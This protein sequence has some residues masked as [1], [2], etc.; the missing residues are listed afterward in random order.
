MVGMGYIDWPDWPDRL[1]K[2]ALGFRLGLSLLESPG[3]GVIGR[4]RVALEILASYQ[5]LNMKF[6]VIFALDCLET[7][8]LWPRWISARTSL[9]LGPVLDLENEHQRA[10]SPTWVG[11]CWHASVQTVAPLHIEKEAVVSLAWPD[12][13]PLG[14]YMPVKGLS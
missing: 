1:G 14:R 13:L 11:L 7:K 5:P 12:V 2:R 10:V 9:Y 4:A 8:T 3:L 6:Q